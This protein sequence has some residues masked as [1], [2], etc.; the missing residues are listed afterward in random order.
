M[1]HIF[2]PFRRSQTREQAQRQGR[3]SG[4]YF[5]AEICRPGSQSNSRPIAHVANY[6]PLYF[7]RKL[8][9]IKS[10]RAI[11]KARGFDLVAALELIARRGREALTPRAMLDLKA[12]LLI[13]DADVIVGDS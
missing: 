4:F 9:E 6:L 3:G 11:A 10:H 1:A 7:Q 12:W 13:R 5:F 2:S 8:V